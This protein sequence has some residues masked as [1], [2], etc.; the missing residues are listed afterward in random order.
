MLSVD[1][2]ALT[3]VVCRPSAE[4]GETEGVLA[5]QAIEMPDASAVC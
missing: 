3:L 2:R 1:I 4:K 5:P